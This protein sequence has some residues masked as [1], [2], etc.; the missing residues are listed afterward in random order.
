M[1]A[2]RDRRA[3]VRAAV[4]RRDGGCVL[5]GT[6]LL[7][8]CAGGPTPHHLLKASA[9]GAYDIDN[10]ICLC[11]GHNTAVED[12][13]TEARRLGLVVRRDITPAD[14]AHRR[15]QWHP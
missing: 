14:A 3:A 7:G 8:P 13:P 5:A 15:Q 1:E 4:Y 9:G 6:G 10:L 12:H 2:D 11:A